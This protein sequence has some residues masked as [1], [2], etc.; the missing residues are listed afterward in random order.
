M[1]TQYFIS[2]V[3]ALSTSGFFFLVLLL[4]ELFFS[5]LWL[6]KQSWC[7]S[8]KVCF[9]FKTQEEEEEEVNLDAE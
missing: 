2:F 3:V 8:T 4:F 7:L 6:T 9:P 5:F 1:P